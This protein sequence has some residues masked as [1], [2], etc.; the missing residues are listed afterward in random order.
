[1]RSMLKNWLDQ[2]V[3]SRARRAERREVPGLVAYHSEGVESLPDPVW[4]ISATGMYLLT[5]TR[6]NLGNPVV[7]TLQRQGLPEEHVE[8]R[9]QLKAQPVRWGSDGVGLLFLHTQGTTVKL[10]DGVPH[11][12][13]EPIE[14]VEVVREFRVARAEAL[15][16]QICPAGGEQLSRALR[17]DV[18]S[19]RTESMIEIALR[20]EQMLQN[21]DEA[22][23]ALI[24]PDVLKSIL[25]HGAWAEIDWIRD[26]W[27]SLLMTSC[28][29][30]GRNRDGLEYA[31]L[32]G[33]MNANQTR[34]F[35]WV[36][37]E[38][39]RHLAAS[40]TTELE[41]IRCSVAQLKR[42]VGVGDMVRVEREVERLTDLGLLRKG[43]R[44][45]YFD[46]LEDQEMCPTRLAMELFAR[47]HGQR[48]FVPEM[49]NVPAAVAQASM[50]AG[51]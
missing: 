18:G 51:D 28:N 31:G 12:N 23:R 35:N 25:D 16:R 50:N 24:H 32:L 29:P 27:S 2:P 41:P 13:S 22:D 48:Q 26:M 34:V 40:G 30:D 36:C 33:E 1:M 5:S 45:V 42:I 38:A 6:W 8:N 17:S 11:A 39:A 46:E 43:T 10:W 37:G 44:R 7:V 14:P 20:A 15:L 47:S 3:K 4:N 21:G 19:T 9:I 49:F